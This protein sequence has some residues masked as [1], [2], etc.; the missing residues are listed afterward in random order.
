MTKV[1]LPTGKN[2]LGLASLKVIPDRV[3]VSVLKPMNTAPGGVGWS[4]EFHDQLCVLG[5]GSEKK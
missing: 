4:Q 2:G 1:F 3:P 5:F